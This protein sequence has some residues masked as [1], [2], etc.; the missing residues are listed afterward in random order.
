MLPRSGD[1]NLFEHVAK[2]LGTKKEYRILDHRT[3]WNK[4]W[5]KLGKGAA[6]IADNERGA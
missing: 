2:P 5:R 3:D 4:R 1:H 6:C